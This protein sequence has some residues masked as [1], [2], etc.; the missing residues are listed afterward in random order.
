MPAN[1]RSSRY[2]FSLWTVWI[3][4]VVVIL[5]LILPKM[6]DA[7][8]DF[9]RMEQ[10]AAEEYGQAAAATI[11][12]WRTMIEKNRTQSDLVKLE[13]ANNFV[14]HRV[15]Y[16][17]D[18]LVWGVDDYWATPL[19]VFG[20]GRGDC[21]D[22]AIAK[23]I[24]LLLM[25]VPVQRL[26]LVYARARMGSQTVAHLVL[27][28][29]ETPTSDPLIMDNLIDAILP[30]KRR[31]DL[32]P[33]FSFNHE[34]LWMGGERNPTGDPTA[35]LSRWRDVLQRMRREGID[36]SLTRLSAQSTMS[37]EKPKP[38]SSPKNMAKARSP[39]K[40]AAK[41]Q[42]SQKRTAS[43]PAKSTAKTAKKQPPS[44]RIAKR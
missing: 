37:W 30:A 11:K 13:S 27:S 43:N 9:G 40:V 12:A 35:R 44:R 33:I 34:G 19:E 32:F 3:G 22:Y 23:Y 15:S 17:S 41:N 31:P 25:D 5:L 29:Y 39:S 24:S 10:L 2:P 18:M 20:K 38:H 36:P 28:Y 4:R 8:T 6:A 21:E 7:R 26:R 1:H 16:A 42:V 14:N